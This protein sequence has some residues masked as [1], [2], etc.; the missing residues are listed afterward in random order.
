MPRRFENG[1]SGWG[2][3]MN[4]NTLHVGPRY[5]PLPVKLD[6]LRKH[7]V[8]GFSRRKGPWRGIEYVE[9]AT[10]EWV[11]WFNTR[12]LPEPVGN[13]PPAELEEIFYSRQKILRQEAV[14]P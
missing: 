14:L 11:W 4:T 7:F 2:S 12:R 3:N 5:H 8:G 6:V 1:P 10:L 9:F 13:I